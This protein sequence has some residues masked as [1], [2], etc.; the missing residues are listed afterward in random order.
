MGVK[1]VQALG[2]E[3]PE[4]RYQISQ[5]ELKQ[6]SW[7]SED[8]RFFVCRIKTLVLSLQFLK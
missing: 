1:S 3:I 5:L 8:F 7:T 4:F 6:I 2:S